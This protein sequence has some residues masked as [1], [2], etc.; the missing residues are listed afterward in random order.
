MGTCCRPRRRISGEVRA[1]EG[2]RREKRWK[3]SRAGVHGMGWGGVYILQCDQ[4]AKRFMRCARCGSGHKR[5]EAVCAKFDVVLKST[6]AGS[7][8]PSSHTA[9]EER[10]DSKGRHEAILPA[11]VCDSISSTIISP[12]VGADIRHAASEGYWNTL[13]GYA[14]VS[15]LYIL[16]FKYRYITC[17]ELHRSSTSFAPFTAPTPS[18]PSPA[19]VPVLPNHGL[20]T[21]HRPSSK[22]HTPLHHPLPRRL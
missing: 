10:P 17:S 19:Q 7:D 20:G 22:P 3:G 11:A 1:C 4:M 18:A 16:R 21:P 13:S 8:R 6:R 2:G 14:R 12:R 9:N 15:N 5:A